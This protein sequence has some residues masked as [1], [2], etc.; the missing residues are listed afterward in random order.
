M[1]FAR[2]HFKILIVAAACTAIGAGASA[3]A[4]AGASTATTTAATPKAHTAR[5][6]L[7]ARALARR[8]IQAD[9]VVATRQG[10]EAVTFER[11]FVESVSGQQ[12]TIK[13]G[14]VKSTYKTVTLTIPSNAKVRDDGHASTLSALTAG[15][16][17]WVVQ[18][19]N[20]T[21]VIAR[22]APAS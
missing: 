2:K 1:R 5:V 7:G 17:V 20:V 11:G 9:V 22:P 4:T 12:L 21:H 3:I 16:R 15:Q 6:P 14:T 18:G 8:A 19:P 13:E 10:F